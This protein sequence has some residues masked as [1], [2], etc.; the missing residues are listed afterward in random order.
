MAKL[1]VLFGNRSVCQPWAKRHDV[2]FS[3]IDYL[4]MEEQIALVK[5]LCK[6]VQE[7]S[8]ANK[9]VVIHSHFPIHAYVVNNELQRKKSNQGDGIDIEKVDAL[10]I[11]DDNT[12]TDLMDREDTGLMYCSPYERIVDDISDEFMYLLNR[13]GM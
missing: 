11:K 2:V 13:E 10:W 6:V 1:V 7:S 4:A 3:N 12:E 8:N 9:T 5:D